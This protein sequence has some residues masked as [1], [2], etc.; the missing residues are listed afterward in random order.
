MAKKHRDDERGT[1]KG[2]VT[3]TEAGQHGDKA[4]EFIQ[5]EQI[6]SSRA[7]S[8]KGEDAAGDPNHDDPGQQRL[9]ENREQHDEAEK[10]SE[11]TRLSK[12]VQRHGHDRE[13]FDKILGGK[14]RHPAMPEE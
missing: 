4:H 12:D 11:A 13:Q 14:E 9:F 1:Q 10:N 8:A 5:T 3:H 2:A 7:Q 6:R